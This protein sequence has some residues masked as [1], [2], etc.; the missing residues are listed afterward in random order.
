[1]LMHLWRIIGP[2]CRPIYEG[3]IRLGV[4]KR[5][6]SFDLRIYVI[7]SFK[8]KREGFSLFFSFSSI[9]QAFLA[10]REQDAA[11][12][13]L[14]SW[15]LC[16]STRIALSPLFRPLHR[17]RSTCRLRDCSLHFALALVDLPSARRSPRMTMRCRAMTL[18][19]PAGDNAARQNERW[20]WSAI[21]SW[22]ESADTSLIWYF[23]VHYRSARASGVDLAMRLIG[24]IDMS[25][26]FG[27]S[28]PA[29]LNIL[30]LSHAF[31]FYL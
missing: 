7:A 17:A 22:Y 21:A 18:R 20:C 14:L 12:K 26:L 5:V 6:F 27:R 1:M 3:R 15:Y 8:D 31:R 2:F 28:M 10:L 30:L 19:S 4:G 25:L 29:L 24:P 16:R 9:D 11:C 13:M 23:N